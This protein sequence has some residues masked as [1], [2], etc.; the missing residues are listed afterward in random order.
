MPISR[1]QQSEKKAQKAQNHFF[2]VPTATLPLEI[3]GSGERDSKDG[4]PQNFLLLKIIF[5]S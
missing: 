2:C 1:N 5:T 3:I 4:F